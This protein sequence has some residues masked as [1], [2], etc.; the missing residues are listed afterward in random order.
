MM[1]K[2]VIDMISSNCPNPIYP[3][4]KFS[5]KYHIIYLMSKLNENLPKFNE[6]RIVQ[7]LL[8]IIINIL[9]FR[10]IKN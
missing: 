2:G 5:K 8:D 3:I 1:S 6:K 9:L 10:I 7:N 4:K